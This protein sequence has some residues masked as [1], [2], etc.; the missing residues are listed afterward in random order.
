MRTVGTIVRGIRTP[1]IRHGDDLEQI[2]MDSI[3][4]AAKNENFKLNDRDV[5]GITEA[6]VSITQG[7]FVTLDQLSKEFKK[8]FPSKVG[9]VF[10]IL[11]R[12]R[13]SLILKALA[14]VSKEVHVLL[15]YPSDE[16]GNQLVNSEVMDAKGVDPF[17]D[18]FE[19]REFREIFGDKLAH[20]FTGVDYIEAYKKLGDGNVTIHFSNDPTSILKYTKNVL[21]SDIHTRFK[22]KKIIKKAGGKLII[23]LDEIC[24]KKIRKHG[25]NIEY[26][27]LGSNKVAEDRLKLFPR[28]CD[29]FVDKIKDRI[30]K[31]YKKEVEVLVYGDGAFKDPVGKIWELADPVV[32]PGFTEKLIGTPKELKLKYISENWDSQGDLG[33]Y[34]KSM[35][36]MKNTKDYDVEKSL[37]TTP[38]QLTDL[39]GSLCDLTSGSGDKGT[40][41]VLVQG[42]FDDYTVE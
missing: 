12:N 22:T 37:G 17:K 20:R 39:L 32:C 42:Y 8:V 5:I 38:R 29:I 27:L 11:S 28:D 15:S 33:D 24:N 35:I 16:V 26:G 36:R 23:G 19:E 13:F 10:P 18:S 25:Y 4:R 30:K 21:V 41:V 40:P 3:E 34:V 7:N 31:R 2:V 1:I 9:V 6:V 14:D